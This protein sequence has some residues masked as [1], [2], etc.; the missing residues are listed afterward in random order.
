MLQKFIC[1]VVYR[2]GGTHAAENQKSTLENS[3]QKPF[4]RRQNYISYKN[5][6][7]KKYVIKLSQNQQLFSF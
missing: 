5:I 7:H 6:Q 1:V 4:Q 3:R 2:S